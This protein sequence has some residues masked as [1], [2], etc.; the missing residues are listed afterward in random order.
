MRNKKRFQR[1]DHT[2]SIGCLDTNSAG[3]SG[4]D[5]GGFIERGQRD[6]I[7]AMWKY[8][9]QDCS[10]MKRQ[11]RFANTSC[12]YQSKQAHFGALKQMDNLL[13]LLFTPNQRFL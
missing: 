6:K 2:C 11:P 9:L 7:D 3:Q 10:D 8:R 1:L 4:D 13:D 5:L 12:S